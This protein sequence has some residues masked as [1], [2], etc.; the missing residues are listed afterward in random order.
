MIAS[1]FFFQKVFETDLVWI[2]RG[3]ILAGGGDSLYGI[4]GLVSE[5]RSAKRD[6]I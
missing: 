4:F 6:L 1:Y 5:A 3:L 2:P